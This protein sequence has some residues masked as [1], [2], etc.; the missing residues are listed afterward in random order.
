ML[1]FECNRYRLRPQ[2]LGGL[3]NKDFLGPVLNLPIP[4]N[5]RLS[6]HVLPGLAL[7]WVGF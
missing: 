3:S 6:T 4:L 7:D 1:R 5:S 2:G